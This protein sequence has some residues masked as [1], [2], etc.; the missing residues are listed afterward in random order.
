VPASEFNRLEPE[1]GPNELTLDLQSGSIQ[2]NE[3]TIKT[4]GTEFRRPVQVDGSDD[5]KSWSRLVTASV[6]LFSAEKQ[7]FE[8][9]SFSFA[10]SRYRYLRV[11]VYPDPYPEED[12]DTSFRILDASVWRYVDVPGE[13]LTREG[14][15]KQ[16]EPVRSFRAPASAWIIELGGDRIPCDQIEV[17]VADAEFA[18][19]ISVATEYPTGPLGQNEF[20]PV[21]LKNESLWQRKPGDPMK[22]MIAVF[23]EVQTR[24]L[25]L[26]VTDH[27]NPPLSIRSIKFSA[28]ARQIVFARPANSI[29]D[30]RLNF[31][32]PVAEP[33]NYD[34]ARNLPPKLV[35][36]P[37]RT[38]AGAATTNPDFIPPPQPLTERWPWLIYAVLGS[39]SVVLAVLIL[40]LSRAAIAV[41]D[42]A[43]QSGPAPSVG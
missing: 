20:V 19:D 8:V 16:R 31:G 2:Y 43:N 37:T 26:E 25:K 15:V 14:V 10:D 40:G 34:F 4:S 33:P 39:I 28:A 23:D 29:G 9:A 13:R 6:M 36:P 5:A 35:P 12:R 7:K 18:R 11:R 38:E 21:G 27:R 1:E 17:D 42:S 30:L 32:N 3:I 22:P 24:R 41:H